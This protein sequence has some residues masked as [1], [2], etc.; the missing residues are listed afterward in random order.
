V[1]PDGGIKRILVVKP[2][3]LGDIVHSLPFLSALKRRWPGSKVHWV[4]ARGLEGLLEGHPLVER[5]WIIDKG[6]WKKL[7]NIFSTIG[8]LRT[9]FRELKA[10]RFDVAVDLQGLFRSGLITWRSGAPIRIGFSE[11]REGSTLFYN[12][13]IE[14]GINRDVHAI[15]RYLKIAASLDCD[16]SLIDYPFPPLP[17]VGHLGLPNEYVV[18][19]PSAGKEANRWPAERFGEVAARTPV[20]TVIISSKTDEPIANKVIQNSQGKAL[21]I[22]GKTSLLEMAAV[23]SKARAMVCNDT[24]PMHIAAALGVPVVAIFGPA[25][26]ART[27]PYGFGHTVIHEELDCSPCYAKKQCDDPKCLENITAERVLS[28]VTEKLN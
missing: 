10:Q 28:A 8:E 11:A 27:G 21:S 2:S 9:L 14:S 20:P 22:A 17:N 15:N 5:L 19:S 6:K 25:N 26:P 23:I 12:E 3:A 1:L 13:K 7:S 18:M 4:I 24:G 16:T